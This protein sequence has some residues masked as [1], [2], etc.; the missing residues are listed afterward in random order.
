MP[1]PIDTAHIPIKI[2]PVT[3]WMTINKHPNAKPSCINAHTPHSDCM[4]S[5]LSDAMRGYFSHPTVTPMSEAT[6]AR[7]AKYPAAANALL[8]DDVEG[9][10]ELIMVLIMS[11][12]NATLQ[13]F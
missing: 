4:R 2:A 12:A 8:G 5:D 6:N 10:P 13:R 11:P 1:A 3:G 7:D 9:T